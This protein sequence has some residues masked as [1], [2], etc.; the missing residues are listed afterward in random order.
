MN[1]LSFNQLNLSDIKLIVCD[2]DGTL[3]ND[4]NELTE[5]TINTFREFAK[6]YPDIKIVFAT[7]RSYKTSFPIAKELLLW[8]SFI[9][10]NNGAVLT[11]FTEFLPLREYKMDYKKAKTIIAHTKT[12]QLNTVIFIGD[13]KTLISNQIYAHR[14]IPEVWKWPFEFEIASD[15]LKAHHHIYQISTWV[16]NEQVE[17]FVQF[18]EGKLKFQI[19]YY[20]HETFT[21][22]EIT[23]NNVNKWLMI[24]YLYKHLK[25][26]PHNILVFGNGNNDAEMLKRAG[27]GICVN[28]GDP[29]ALEAADFII[30]SNNHN[31][32]ASFIRKAW[33]K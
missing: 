23:E 33:L 12:L 30:E 29:E 16:T 22:F 6:K 21:Y 2:I 31:G 5:Y 10:T 19:Y 14:K 3:L 13:S 18:V 25:L 20:H 28:N 27:Y 9:I 32:V 4:L 24:D 11:T 1:Q 15:E 17:E 26:Q 7:G 8:E